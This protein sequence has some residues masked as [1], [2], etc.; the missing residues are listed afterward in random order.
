MRTEQKSDRSQWQGNGQ[1]R[2]VGHHVHPVG[3][4]HAIGEERIRAISE[5]PCTVRQHPLEESLILRIITQFMIKIEP[6]RCCDEEGNGYETRDCQN[7]APG[8]HPPL[9]TALISLSYLL[10]SRFH[11]WRGCRRSVRR[12]G[13]P[14]GEQLGVQVVVGGHLAR[15]ENVLAGRLACRVKT[16][17]RHSIGEPNRGS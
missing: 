6:Q 4:I 1:H 10:F 15:P 16:R 9:R 14:E 3:V 13:S 8:E 2:R 11:G 5:H 17:N 7:V 12:D